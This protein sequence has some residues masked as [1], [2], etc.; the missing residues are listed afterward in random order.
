M[1]TF[2]L[3]L[4]LCVCASAQVTQGPVTARTT[5]PQPSP[6]KL[7]DDLTIPPEQSKTLKQLQAKLVD[8][9]QQEMVIKLL[10]ENTIMESALRLGLNKAQLDAVEAREVEAGKF[11][12]EPKKTN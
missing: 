5:A 7:P 1:K 11:K 6:V 10:I 2:I 9:Q 8:L 4:V 3:I 12:F